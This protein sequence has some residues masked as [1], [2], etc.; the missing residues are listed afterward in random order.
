M[1]MTRGK[2]NRSDYISTAREHIFILA[3]ITDRDVFQ[4]GADAKVMAEWRCNHENAFAACVHSWRPPHTSPVPPTRSTSRPR[5]AAS[6][7]T[8][9]WCLWGEGRRCRPGLQSGRCGD[10][11]TRMPLRIGSNRR[12]WRWTGT[13]VHSTLAQAR[14]VGFK[15]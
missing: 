6:P 2:L 13:T 10:A 14:S 4:R 9:R 8:G 3:K 11:I 5:H 1:L 12:I 15:S 7:T